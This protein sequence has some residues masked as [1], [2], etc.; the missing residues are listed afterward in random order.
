MQ[1]GKLTIY[2]TKNGESF[3]ITVDSI[4]SFVGYEKIEREFVVAYR[5][6]KW[7]SG[8]HSV[9]KAI[10][11]RFFD[12]PARAAFLEAELSKEENK[13]V[14]PEIE[15]RN[16]ALG[17]RGFGKKRVAQGSPDGQLPQKVGVGA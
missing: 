2:Y 13:M 16:S 12:Q 6:E 1:E 11:E 7:L 5:G 8:A 14:L 15:Q 3:Q 9:F 4:S 17:A 10:A